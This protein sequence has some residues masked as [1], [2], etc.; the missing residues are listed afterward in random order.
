MEG[1]DNLVYFLSIA[2][3]QQ[4][5]AYLREQEAYS[6]QN[7]KSLTDDIQ[8][9]QGAIAT[10]SEIRKAIL[11]ARRENVEE[12]Q[13]S[14][15][16]E[17]D[18]PDDEETKIAKVERQIRSTRRLF[19]EKKAFLG[20]FLG[21]VDPVDQETGEGGQFSRLLQELWNAF[22]SKNPETARGFIKVSDLVRRSERI[23]CQ[24]SILF[25]FAAF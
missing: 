5:N 23:L 20:E 17:A 16:K 9:T 11:K 7:I 12:P 13:P 18:V 19:K 25:L 14:T 8:E 22:Q 2:D 15:S 6:H 24:I 10:L 3:L 1:E 4:T 21:K